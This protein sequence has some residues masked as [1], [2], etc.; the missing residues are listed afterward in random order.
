MP[1]KVF[2]HVGLHKTG[3]TYLQNIW[4]ANADDL[5]AQG[6][7]YL[8][9]AVD[10]QMLAVLDLQGRRRVR[11]FHD[12]RVGGSWDQLVE[13]VNA[14]ASPDADVTEPGALVHTLVVAARED[15]EVA[16][17]TRRVLGG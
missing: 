2:L 8:A 6:V 12:R 17:E 9:G 13:A 7:L 5:M 3:T 10:V 11:G 1:R 15:L 4:R 16:R 14:T